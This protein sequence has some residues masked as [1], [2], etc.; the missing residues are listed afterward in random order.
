MVQLESGY[1]LAVGEDRWL[2]ELSE[3]PAIQEGLQNVLLDIQVVV[4]DRCHPLAEL[5]KILHCLLDAVVGDVVGGG[6]GAQIQM[7]SHVLLD[8]PIAVN[9]FGSPGWAGRYL[10]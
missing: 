1:P 9:D 2:G 10:R 4:S 8:K 6:F 5:G 7:V 3:L